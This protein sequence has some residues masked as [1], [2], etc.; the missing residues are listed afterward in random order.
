MR[1]GLV[2]AAAVVGCAALSCEDKKENPARPASPA[3]TAGKA[4][5][6]APSAKA[7]SPAAPVRVSAAARP[8]TVTVAGVEAGKLDEITAQV[9]ALEG[10]ASVELV[11]F[12]QGRLTFKASSRLPGG[13]LWRKV[14]FGRVT[15]FAA[16]ALEINLAVPAVKQPAAAR[17][18][19][20]ASPTP[21]PRRDPRFVGRWEASVNPYGGP[22]VT[23]VMMNFH[24]DGTFDS[25]MTVGFNAPVKSRGRWRT[26]G[27][28][29]IVT[30]GGK[31]ERYDV[32]WK[33][34]GWEAV[35]AG[36][37]VVFFRK[38]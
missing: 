2:L 13:E 19:G 31:T 9:K 23:V 4:P 10:V 37:G 11:S 27:A 34:G 21:A 38:R 3:A 33:V 14:R 18:S 25:E 28:E 8:L 35:L 30:E 15:G 20:A 26:E 1:A 16:D 29:L 7:A 36:V 22:V 12:Q 32:E 6:P 17:P 5:G 24:A